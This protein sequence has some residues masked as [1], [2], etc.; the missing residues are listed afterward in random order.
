MYVLATKYAIYKD[1][2]CSFPANAQS[3]ITIASA[4]VDGRETSFMHSHETAAAKQS[5]VCS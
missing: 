3:V 1:N 2:N 4:M 5:G